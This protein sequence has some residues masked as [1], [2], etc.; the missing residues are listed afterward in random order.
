MVARSHAWHGHLLPTEVR[1]DEQRKET[2]TL[3][4]GE[5]QSRV[6]ASLRPLQGE[7]SKCDTLRVVRVRR[8]RRQHV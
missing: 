8:E 2:S 3:L 6:M 7:S 1:C 4:E 5:L